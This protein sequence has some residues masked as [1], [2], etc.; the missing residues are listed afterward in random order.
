[1]SPVTAWP[2]PSNYQLCLAVECRPL[3]VKHADGCV[4]EKFW[5]LVFA[6]E[7]KNLVIQ[8]MSSILVFFWMINILILNV[9]N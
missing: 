6:C 8:I 3:L 2:P 4:V 9:I 5:S 7:N 1:M